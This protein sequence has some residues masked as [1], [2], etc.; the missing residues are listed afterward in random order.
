MR[1]PIIPMLSGMLFGAGLAVS[2]M[3]NPKRVRGFLDVLG[4]WDPT[5]AF[6]MGGA[7]AVM[8]GAWLFQK[9][10]AKPVFA[11]EFHLPPTQ[12][13]DRKLIG[14]A[15]LFGTGWGI[16]GL[17]PGPAIGALVVEPLSAVIFV[18]SMVIGIAVHRAVSGM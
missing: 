11:P 6:V 5:L 13:I 18:G 17:C 12:R 14:G 7:L 1:S 9:N 10:L 15:I 4:G 3:M 2:G 16:A 8:A